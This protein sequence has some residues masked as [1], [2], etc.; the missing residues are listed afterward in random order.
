MKVWGLGPHCSRPLNLP[1]FESHYVHDAFHNQ[2]LRLYLLR[3]LSKPALWPSDIILSGF[4]LRV[5]SFFLALGEQSTASCA[6][7]ASEFDC[8][9]HRGHS[10][11]QIRAVSEVSSNEAQAPTLSL[12]FQWA[13]TCSFTVTR[14]TF[15]M[16]TPVLDH[17]RASWH[18]TSPIRPTKVAPHQIPMTP[19]KDWRVMTAQRS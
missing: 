2:S 16:S 8:G 9:M 10:E 19:S 13:P 6:G 12:R 18:T 5:L 17:L 15:R 1:R 4:H 3:K 11:T 14:A 7:R